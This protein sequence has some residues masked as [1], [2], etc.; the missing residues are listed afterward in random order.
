MTECRLNAIAVLEDRIKRTET[1]LKYMKSFL[2]WLEEKKPEG[3]AE[4]VLWSL[5]V[6]KDE[7]YYF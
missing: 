4:E 5:M 7:C 1:R 6:N 2:R 3:E